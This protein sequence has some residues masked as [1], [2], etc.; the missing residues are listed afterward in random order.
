MSTSTIPSRPG[1]PLH[2]PDLDPQAALQALNLLDAVIAAIW[3]THGDAIL[4]LLSRLPTTQPPPT[5]NASD[6]PF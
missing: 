5:P 1:M 3:A 6:V 2:L 4:H